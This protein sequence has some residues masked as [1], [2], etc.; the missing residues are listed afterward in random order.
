MVD[1]DEYKYFLSLDF[2]MSF[3]NKSQS[4]LLRSQII[5]PLQL[6]ITTVLFNSTPT[7]FNMQNLVK[8]I[9]H[10]TYPGVDPKRPELSLAGKTIVLTG[11]GDG[12][13][14]N[15][16]L[17]LAK[18]GC[19]PIHVI[20]RTLKTLNA[21]K[22][23]VEKAVPGSQVIVHVGDVA[24]SAAMKKAASEVG[25]WDVYIANAGIFPAKS[26][27]KDADI[28]KWWTGFEVFPSHDGTQRY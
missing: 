1:Q 6:L 15:T 10:E 2:R 4:A 26:S 12:I 8:T 27:L 3:N 22:E 5:K 13:G 25:H 20:G 14:R 28:D 21:T 19:G 16:A 11:A 7:L 24:D 18:A 17:E 9:H 23:S